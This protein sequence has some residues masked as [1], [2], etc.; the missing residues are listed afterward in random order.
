MQLKTAAQPFAGL[1]LVAVVSV[2][3]PRKSYVLGPVRAVMLIYC[4]IIY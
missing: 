1:D 4:R 3:L 2:N